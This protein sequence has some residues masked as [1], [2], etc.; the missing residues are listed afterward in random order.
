MAVASTASNAEG[1]P[2]RIECLDSYSVDYKKAAD[3]LS[4]SAVGPDMEVVGQWTGVDAGFAIES[5]V[6]PPSPDEPNPVRFEFSVSS[7]SNPRLDEEFT[8]F[9]NGDC[10]AR[11]KG[12][13][14]TPR[15]KGKGKG[16]DQGRGRG[17]GSKGTGP[18]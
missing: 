15:G 1:M 12:L 9:A 17:R 10:K 3:S 2:A 8:Y 14:V 6:K 13:T 11:G 7:S 18:Y 5:N 16:K 4:L